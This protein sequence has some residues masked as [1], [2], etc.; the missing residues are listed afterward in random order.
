MGSCMYLYSLYGVGW[1]DG[2]SRDLSLLHH[3][4]ITDAKSHGI[5][6]RNGREQAL[7]N[8]ICFGE[9]GVKDGYQASGQQKRSAQEQI[10]GRT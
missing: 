8:G 1:E 4:T 9:D 2:R 10:M 5:K 3:G 6:D 7:K